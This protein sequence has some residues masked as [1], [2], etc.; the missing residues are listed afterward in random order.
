MSMASY[1]LYSITSFEKHKNSNPVDTLFIDL[2]ADV[3]L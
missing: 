1:V 2:L 3:L